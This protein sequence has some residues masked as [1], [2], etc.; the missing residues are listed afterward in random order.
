VSYDPA[1]GRERATA[2][3]TLHN[4]APASGLPDYV[5]R[6][7][8]DPS[9][10]SGTNR[11]YLSIYSPFGL[12]GS[13]VDGNAT[14]FQS[15]REFGYHVYSQYLSVPPGGTVTVVLDLAGQ[16]S[17]GVDYHLGVGIQPTVTPDQLHLVVTPTPGWMV[18]STDILR[19]EVD[20]AQASYLAQP[21]H[22]LDAAVRFR[23][24]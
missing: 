1:T 21:G 13:H 23:V 22:P 16:L 20:H 6:D 17:S 9:T 19:D 4:D 7:N 15:Q 10:P 12:T 3:V 14:P 24:G 8:K 2:T 18:E 11:M 5:I